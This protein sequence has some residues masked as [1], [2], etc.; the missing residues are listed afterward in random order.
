MY[1]VNVTD[2]NNNTVTKKLI[3]K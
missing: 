2:Q 1:F 3:L